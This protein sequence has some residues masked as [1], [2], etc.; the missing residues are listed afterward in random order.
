VHGVEVSPDAVRSAA[1]R[2]MTGEVGTQVEPMSSG[3]LDR[4]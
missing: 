4:P 1:R 3:A 2:G